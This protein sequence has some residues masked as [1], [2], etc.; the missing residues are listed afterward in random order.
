L[1]VKEG[2]L[3]IRGRSIREDQNGLICLDDIWALSGASDTR[4]PKHWRTGVKDLISAVFS[5]VRKSD[6]MDN[7][8]I[9]SIIYAERGKFSTGTYAHPLLAVAYAAYLHPKLKVEVL[10]VW[11]R[12]R[13]GDATLADDVLDRA[14]PEANRWAAVRAMARTK[15]VAKHVSGFVLAIQITADLKCGNALSAIH[16]NRDSAENVTQRHLA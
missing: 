8:S 12:Y 9:R 10:E 2:Q 11:M 13:Q 6:R 1:I 7:I 16:E 14:S 3:V 5:K 15:R 4:R